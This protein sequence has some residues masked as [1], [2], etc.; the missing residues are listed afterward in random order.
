MFCEVSA[1]P[2][3]ATTQK[4]CSRAQGLGEVERCENSPWAMVAGELPTAPAA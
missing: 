2:A 4:A 3:V 1:V